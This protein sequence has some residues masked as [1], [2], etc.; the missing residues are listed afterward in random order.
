MALFCYIAIIIIVINI[1]ITI[2][3]VTIT[4]VILCVMILGPKSVL[5]LTAKFNYAQGF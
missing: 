3:I 2:T 5:K 4:N 1:V